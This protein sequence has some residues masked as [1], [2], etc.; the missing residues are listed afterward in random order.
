MCSTIN[1]ILSIFFFM[2]FYYKFFFFFTHSLF[3]Y[4]LIVVSPSLAHMYTLCFSLLNRITVSFFTNQ[5]HKYRTQTGF[6][7]IFFVS[8]TNTVPTFYDLSTRSRMPSS[9]AFHCSSRYEFLIEVDG[10]KNSISE[11]REQADETTSI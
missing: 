3:F 5:A 9:P 6:A 11:N 7:D 10:K 1:N 4:F 2:R 8:T